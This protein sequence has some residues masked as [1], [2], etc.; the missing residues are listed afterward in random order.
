MARTSPLSPWYSRLLGNAEWPHYLKNARNFCHCLLCMCYHEHA[1]HGFECS[2]HF[3]WVWVFHLPSRS[4]HSRHYPQAAR[5]MW[6]RACKSL[7][8][9][10][11]PVFLTECPQG[12]W[13]S[14]VTQPE[15]ACNSAYRQSFQEEKALSKLGD[16]VLQND[17]VNWFFQGH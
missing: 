4:R 1:F 2:A 11:V 14:Q 9:M 8:I 5:W 16:A 17:G 13:W 7:G 6:V 15:R 10:E 3:S 12:H